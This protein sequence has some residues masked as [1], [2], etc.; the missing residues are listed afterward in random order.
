MDSLNLFLRDKAWVKMGNIELERKYVSR[1]FKGFWVVLM[2]VD[3]EPTVGIGSDV[4]GISLEST[5]CVGLS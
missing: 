3:L 2:G 5:N 1:S 4:P